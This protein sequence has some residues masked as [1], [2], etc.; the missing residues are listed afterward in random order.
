MSKVASVQEFIV[1]YLRENGAS[2]INELYVSSG[3]SKDTFYKALNGLIDE[4]VVVT[5]RDGK[6]RYVKL[7]AVFPDYLKYVV[8]ITCVVVFLSTATLTKYKLLFVDFGSSYPIV[9][10]DSSFFY[11][12]L[13]YLIGLWTGIVFFRAEDL[14]S[15][16]I[17]IKSYFKW[18]NLMKKR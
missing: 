1:E 4:G 18:T 10:P 13:M 16:Y 5:Y 15:A 14:E 2:F 6:R 7:I 8:L 17:Y 12:L 11:L 3:V 9:F